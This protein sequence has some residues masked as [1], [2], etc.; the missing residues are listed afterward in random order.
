MVK[1][2]S[3]RLEDSLSAKLDALAAS[4]E[5]PKA[6]LIE[7][8]IRT[9]VQEQSWQVKAIEEAIT[10]YRSGKAEVVP[11]EQVMEQL[12]GRIKA[13]LSK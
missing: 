2:T 11:H 4:I 13:K 1:I 12:E 10:E 6:W 8:A 7:Q 5:R 9:Y 3:V